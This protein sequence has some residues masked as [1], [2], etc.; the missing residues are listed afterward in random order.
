MLFI[1]SLVSELESVSWGSRENAQANLG[2]LGLSAIEPI[3]TKLQD[4]NEEIRNKFAGALSYISDLKSQEIL[5]ELTKNDSISVQIA[6]SKALANMGDKRAIDPLIILLESDDWQIR[7][8][9]QETIGKIGLPAIESLMGKLKDKNEEAQNNAAYT[10]AYVNDLKAVEVL[11]ELTKYNLASVRSAASKALGNIGDKRAI[12]PLI[13]LLA[14]ADWQVYENAQESLGKLGQPAIEPLLVKLQDKDEKIRQRAATALANIGEIAVTPLSQLLQSSDW[15]VRESVVIALGGI[16]HDSAAQILLGV[17]NDT[18]YKVRLAAVKSLGRI[19]N[20]TSVEGLLNILTRSL[21]STRKTAADELLKLHSEHAVNAVINALRHNN[22]QVQILII[23]AIEKYAREF[24][25]EYD[26]FPSWFDIYKDRYQIHLSESAKTVVDILIN[27]SREANRLSPTWCDNQCLSFLVVLLGKALKTIFPENYPYSS[28]FHKVREV[29]LSTLSEVYQLIN[30][31]RLSK[32]DD[33]RGT[34]YFSAPPSNLHFE[35]P[36][37]EKARLALQIATSTTLEKASESR[38]ADITFYYDE[39]DSETKVSDGHVLKCGQW[40]KLEVA[41]RSK[42]TGVPSQEPERRR[43]REPKQQEPVTIIITAEGDGFE[44]KEPVQTLLLPPMGDSTENANFQ[45]RPLHQSASDKDLASI[46]IRAYY[47]FNLLEVSIIQAEVVGKFDDSSQ[48]KLGLEKPIS[49]RQERLEREYLDFDEVE[50]KAMHIDITKENECFLFNF[51]FY[52]NLAQRVEF[53]APIHLP[54][55]D[56]EDALLTIRQTWYDISMSKIF[57]ERVEGDDE[58]F[59]KNIRELAKVGQ[60]LWIKLFQ[61]DSGSAMYK[62]GQWLEDNPLQKGSIIQVSLAE[63]A[64]EFIFPWALIYDR[65]VPIKD[66][67]LPDIEGFWG[68]RYCIELQ[69]TNQNKGTDKPV[70]IQ[71]KLRVGFMLWEQFRNADMQKVL[72]ENW[73]QRNPDKLDITLP[74]ITDA[75][76]CYALLDDCDAHILYFYTHGHTRHR[77]AD[78]GVEENLKS[79]ISRYESLKKDDPRHE[80]WKFLYESVKQDKSEPDSSWIELSYGKLELNELYGN[81]SQLRSKPLVF[82]NMC[83]SAQI[84]PSLS[85]SFIDFF[86][87]RGARGVIGTECPMTVEFAHPFSEKFLGGLLAGEAVGKALLNARSHFMKLKNPLGLAYTLFGS[88]TTCFQPAIL[89]P[90]TM[91]ATTNVSTE[92]SSDA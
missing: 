36:E 25:I 67:E 33:D 21:E 90:L 79:F 7:S 15:Q 59:L 87:D 77:Q 32:R 92:S 70:Q 27:L 5:V 57:T 86:I 10:L 1:E 35:L 45:V 42:P 62:V 40:Y 43:I 75:D 60:N 37:E 4:D 68:L 20:E 69:L 64:K 34:C 85:D 73:K 65:K 22:P 14:D 38:Y 18:N 2:R 49:F 81:I 28:C 54:D 41:V 12:Q 82:L 52:N 39:N 23:N 8:N 89:K 31:I 24:N 46:R 76:D 56:L 61:L 30:N 19:G 44:I 29:A 26:S 66:Y 47:K 83:E 74:P 9:A 88:A 55:E 84:S 80:L 6:A 91:P 78:I 17:L 3:M 50:P 11:I 58:E 16:K 48:S 53:T 72:M 13:A 51:A 63:N 71:D